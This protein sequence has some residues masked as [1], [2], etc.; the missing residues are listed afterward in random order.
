[1][2]PSGVLRAYPEQTPAL[3]FPF[4]HGV[5]AHHAAGFR[6]HLEVLLVRGR[7]LTWSQALDRL[8]SPAEL[9]GPHFCLSFDDGHRDW[10]EQVVPLLQ[11]HNVPATFFITTGEVVPWAG[12]DRLTWHDVGELVA[13]GMSVGSHSV[14]HPRMSLLD[15]AASR[16]E[17]VRSKEVLED[18]TGG[19]VLDFAAPYGLPGIDYGQREVDLVQAAGYRSLASARPGRTGPGGSPYAIPRSGLS[20]AWPLAA[21]RRRVHE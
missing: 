2:A 15:D 8:A 4:Y 9:E 19:P 18:R 16:E 21:L 12:G 1:M 5:P 6:R 20:P 17:V 14:T 7:F 13:A 11:E 3:Y 10:L